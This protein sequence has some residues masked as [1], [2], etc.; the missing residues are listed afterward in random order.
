ME[1][2]RCG[3]LAVSPKAS[4]HSNPWKFLLT[5]GR[6]CYILYRL[7][8]SWVRAGSSVG[9]SDGLTSR[10]SQVQA[11]SRLPIHI[12]MSSYRTRSVAWLNTSACHAEDRG[13]KSRRVR[14]LVF[15]L[16]HRLFGRQT[17]CGFLLSIPFFVSMTIVLV[18]RMPSCWT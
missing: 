17:V 2:Y 13:F 3:H 16:N 15:R 6:C 5:K 4:L 11:L 18:R 1:W 8:K 14:Q 9:Q 12:Q 7:M 10:R